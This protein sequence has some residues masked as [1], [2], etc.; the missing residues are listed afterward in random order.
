MN[1]SAHTQPHED[2]THHHIASFRSLFAILVILLIMTVLT[3]Y[4]AKFVDLGEMGNLI[5][6]MVI[7]CFKATL[8]CAIFMHLLHDKFLNT[9]ALV[10]CLLLVVTFIGITMI[11]MASRG[12]LDP[13]REHF[14]APPSM[15]E[16]NINAAIEKRD[17]EHAAEGDHGA[18]AE[19]TDDDGHAADDGH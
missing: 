11:D 15:S 16:A 3:V 1:A 10:V 19:H 9:V 7:A 12:T 13:T 6:A 5:L 2:P 18:D 14:I 4:T 17:A 8:V